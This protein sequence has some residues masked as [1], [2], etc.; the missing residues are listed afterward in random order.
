MTRAGSRGDRRP[1]VAMRCE[2][3]FTVIEVTC[4]FTV[5]AVATGMVVGLLASSR[6]AARRT[7]EARL[8]A[9]V[10]QGAYERLRSGAHDALPPGG[11]GVELPLPPEAERLDGAR[12][13]AT[14]APWA[15]T[16]G[17]RAVKVELEWRP[18]RSG[19]WKGAKRRRI[20]REGLV[21]DARAR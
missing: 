15:G 1:P 3:A 8:A 18:R 5:I 20:V 9:S 21:S 10:A 7:V 17:A 6:G 13:V 16:E 12:L 14:S 2:R 4:A 19:G 11:E